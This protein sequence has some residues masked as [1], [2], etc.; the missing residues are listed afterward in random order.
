[1]KRCFFLVL[2]LL[3]ITQMV[4][5]YTGKSFSKKYKELQNSGCVNTACVD[6]MFLW[7]YYLQSSDAVLGDSISNTFLQYANSKSNNYL[8][9]KAFL[10]KAVVANARGKSIEAIPF[11]YTAIELFENKQS[12]DYCFAYQN[13]SKAY[14]N[15]G[16]YK[17]ARESN[18][19]A[20]AV[21]EALKNDVLISNSYNSIGISYNQDKQYKEA[22]PWFRKVI[23]LNEKI[24]KPSAIGYQNL[25]LCFRH[26]GQ[27]DSALAYARKSLVNAEKQGSKHNIAY[28]F[29]EIGATFLEQKQYDTAIL[30]L[31]KSASLFQ[32][33]KESSDIVYVYLYLGNCY[34]AKKNKQAAQHYYRKALVLN[35]YNNN[36]KQLYEVYYQMGKMFSQFK[37]FD[38]AYYY[39]EKYAVLHD[40][41]L[42]AKNELSAA[43]TVASYQLDEKEKNIHILQQKNEINR[44]VVIIATVVLI[45][46]LLIALWWFNHTRYKQKQREIENLQTLQKE[47]DRIARDLHDNV[48]GLLSYIIY[49]L[50]G[51]NDEDKEKRT[52]VTESINLSIRDIVRNLRETIWAISDT[53]INVHD[54]SDKMKLFV[55]TLFKHSS[56]KI[57][58]VESINVDKELNALLGL[59]LY[60]ICQE[61]L[62][63]AFKYANAS[64]VSV[65][66]YSG[67]SKFLISI[68]DNGQGF[69]PSLPHKERYG[70]KNIK[71]RTEEFGISL[72]LDTGI[73]KGTSYTIQV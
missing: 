16:N 7:L 17:L 69:D 4:L 21:A 58:F 47:R 73:N 31:Q 18:K 13:L 32:S 71:K 59:N 20:L 22:I 53:N 40:S 72:T 44:L 51:I 9:A 10:L 55:R 14:G 42:R 64:E 54:F 50:D 3:G 37:V 66:L 48:G 30:Y 5:A 70:L 12:I 68:S 23:K 39:N 52:E 63:N 8:K 15:T 46:I 28:S 56:T 67:E 33:Q 1:M 36:L 49:S 26:L 61:I 11:A 43:A 6:S 34:V 27:Y 62:T 57:N 35:G 24:N 29:S 19:K 2:L 25:G 60:R 65:S 45:L 38:S 41:V